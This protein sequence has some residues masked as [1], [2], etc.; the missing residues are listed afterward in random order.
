MRI[1]YNVKQ[2]AQEDF[3]QTQMAECCNIQVKR[4][5]EEVAKHRWAMGETL[6]L[7]YVPEGKVERTVLV[8]YPS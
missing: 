8:E 7:G 6:G 5:G 4:D 2:L 1:V 3:C